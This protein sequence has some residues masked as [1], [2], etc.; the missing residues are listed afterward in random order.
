MGWPIR[1]ALLLAHIGA[2]AFSSLLLAPRVQAA[3]GCTLGKVAEFPVTMAGYRPLITAKINNQDARFVLDSGAFY[4]M[5]STATAAEFN[6]K[7]KA[8]PYGL[9]LQGIGGAVTTQIATVTDFAIAGALIHNIEFLVGGSEVGSA[10][11]IGQNFLH[12]W[13]V[14]YDF[15]RG[16]VRLFK[17]EGCRKA[18]LAYWLTAGQ[19]YSVTD[20]ESV[21]KSLVHTIGEGYVNG[22][23]IRVMFDTGAYNSVLSLRA[24]ARAGITTDSPGVVEAG[25]SRGIGRAMVKTYI[26]TASSFKIGDGEEIQNARLRITDSDLPDADMLLGSDFF[27]SHHVFV[28]NSQRKL[29]LTYNGGPVF[30]LTKTLS[31]NVGQAAEA[32]K[33]EAAKDGASKDELPKDEGASDHKAG[34]AADQQP[35]P[36]ALARRGEAFAARRDFEHALADLSQ[37]V[38]LR[39]EDPEYLYQRALVYRQSGPAALAAADLDHV[40]TLNPDF[41]RAYMP[42][43]EIRLRERNVDGAIADL[44]AVDRLAPK[45]ADERFLLAERYQA[46]DHFSQ[47]I[48]Q[49]DLWIQNHPVD[50]RIA[51]ALGARCRAS[52]IQNEDLAGGLADCNKALSIADKKNPNY[53]HLFENRGLLELRQANNDKAIADFDAA[54]KTL[55]E[56]SLRALWPRCRETAQEQSGGGGSRHGRGGQDRAAHR[57]AIHRARPGPLDA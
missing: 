6:L 51:M 5:I 29:Y 42:R 30:N 36:D 44:D 14:E 53:G 10:G 37:A 21:T 35:D 55:P 17:P 40:L 49:Y 22:H 48:A 9:R 52:A 3:E 24:A 38:E 2:M 47:A 25:Y 50:S 34:A 27:V 13:D 32:P 28:A 18:R 31:A 46:V 39:P 4:S 8:G 15:S 16:V 54:L 7:L 26:A 23:R 41:L 11:L 33:D 43:A 45:Q 56:K 12:Q 57:G 19:T 20:L 1:T